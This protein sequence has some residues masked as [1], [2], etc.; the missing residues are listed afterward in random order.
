VLS[1][2]AR[3][4]PALLAAA[5]GTIAAALIGAFAVPATGAVPAATTPAVA[6]ARQAEPKA[7]TKSDTESKTTCK[8]SKRKLVPRC[9][10]YL[11]LGPNPRDGESYDQAAQDWENLIGR[12]VDIAHYYVR[13]E[14]SVFPTSLQIMR[15]TEPGRERM[16]F[17]NW[18]PT[19]TW[20][21]IADG[22]SDDY[23]RAVA[24]NV[25]QNFPDRPF[26]LS[27]HAEMEDEVVATDGSG[28]TALDFRD[29]F[30]HVVTVLRTEG[31]TNAKFV[32]DY[33]GAPHW[34]D[35]SWFED[36]YPGRRYVDWIAQDPYS[37]GKPPVWLSD[38]PT[39]VNRVQNP[40]ESQW[41]GFYNWA[42]TSHPRKPVML[43][44]WGV[45]EADDDPQYK[46]E[47]F[48]SILDK[49]DEFPRLKALVYWDCP[50]AGMIGD[51]RVDSSP[52]AL[53]AWIDLVHQPEFTL[54][55]ETLLGRSPTDDR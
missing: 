32:V 7:G 51:T 9:G 50:D 38:F 18:R 19:R 2:S 45:E 20:R 12:T 16:L 42:T 52:Q 30:R 15:A 29:F 4:R 11:G 48:A 14:G 37:F 25:K 43:A 17:I 53:K 54:P 24:A 28:M 1:H 10:V 49:L 6:S 31:V 40:P 35:V 55:G 23:L 41:R 26:F 39:M 13:G 47:F 8:I 46:A 27:L 22:A 44:E 33:I 36:L 34:G 5:T 3:V 21:A